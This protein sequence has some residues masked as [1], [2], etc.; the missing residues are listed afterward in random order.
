MWPFRKH[1]TTTVSVSAPQESTQIRGVRVHLKDLIQARHHIR[2]M[3]ISGK[4][5]SMPCWL[6]ASDPHS[7]A[8]ALILKNRGAISPVTMCG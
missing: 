8:E 7:K 5:R 3:G 1:A 4:T 6:V 2:N